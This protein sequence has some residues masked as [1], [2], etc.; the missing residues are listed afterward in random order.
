MI[1]GLAQR[2][3]QATPHKHLLPCHH[4]SFSS[5]QHFCLLLDTAVS[6]TSTPWLH[7]STP[8]LP[9]S[10]PKADPSLQL[11]ERA[12]PL[13]PQGRSGPYPRQAPLCLHQP[14]HARLGSSRPVRTAGS[15]RVISSMA[16][17]VLHGRCSEGRPINPGLIRLPGWREYGVFDDKSAI[18]CVAHG[19]SSLISTFSTSW[20]HWEA[21]AFD[22]LSV[23]RGSVR[24]ADRFCSMT[25]C[26]W[27]QILRRCKEL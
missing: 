21:Q 11:Q 1:T 9:A 4:S 23:R 24:L 2:P 19:A 18:H 6:S 25:G 13:R 26:R 3:T 10:R 16:C 15:R 27:R 7:R 5:S 22:C 17:S 12:R 14:S 20:A 8:K